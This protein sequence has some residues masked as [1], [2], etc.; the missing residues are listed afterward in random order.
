MT[1]TIDKL[2]SPPLPSPSTA[3]QGDAIRPAEAGVQNWFS[4]SS[5]AATDRQTI[6]ATPEF[7]PDTPHSDIS[8][9]ILSHIEQ[10]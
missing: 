8:R 9:Q 5:L 6:T 3:S 2:G 1:I 10:P 4:G 7:D